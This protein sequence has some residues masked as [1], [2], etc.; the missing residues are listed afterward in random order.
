MALL[1]HWTIDTDRPVFACG[2]LYTRELLSS[3]PTCETCLKAYRKNKPKL[4]DNDY[5]SDLFGDFLGRK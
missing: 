5:I 3:P 2:W 1:S 4:T